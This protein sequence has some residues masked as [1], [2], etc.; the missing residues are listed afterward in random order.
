MEVDNLSCLI[1][2]KQVGETCVICEQIK[3]TGIHLFTSFICTE[4]EKGMISTDTS[5]PKYKYFI[6][7]LRKVS[8]SE[9]FS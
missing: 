6:E 2:N 9:I 3:Q 5:E 1:T 8:S 4:C 7:K